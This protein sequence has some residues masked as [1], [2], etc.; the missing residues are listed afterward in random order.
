MM[1]NNMNVFYYFKWIWNNDTRHSVHCA[2]SHSGID[3][4]GIDGFLLSFY[5]WIATFWS[6]CTCPPLPCEGE[7]S[8]L[9]AIVGIVHCSHRLLLFLYNSS[10][11]TNSFLLDSDTNLLK[12]Q[13]I[14]LQNIY[15]TNT[16][17][18]VT[19]FSQSRKRYERYRNPKNK[20]TS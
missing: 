13:T 9:W 11:D 20:I 15:D 12:I 14:W 17:K 8:T 7:V 10:F 18:G 19:V 1:W 5:W 6:Y 4:L 16:K 2:Y 3:G